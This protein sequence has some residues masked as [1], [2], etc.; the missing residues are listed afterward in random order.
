MRELIVGLALVAAALA[1][2]V[3]HADAHAGETIDATN[4]AAVLEVVLEPR[5]ALWQGLS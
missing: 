5:A 3:A 2:P 1:A 4:P